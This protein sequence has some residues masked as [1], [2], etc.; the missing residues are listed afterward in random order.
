MD[1]SRESAKDVAAR[2]LK[3]EE[4][5]LIRMLSRIGNTNEGGGGETSTA[6][7]PPCDF[8]AKGADS[9]W[10]EEDGWVQDWEGN[11]YREEPDWPQD[12]APVIKATQPGPCCFTC[13]AV[14]G[15]EADMDNP[16]DYYCGSCWDN[17]DKQD[18]P[19]KQP[20][21]PHEDAQEPGTYCD[22]D[23]E[24]DEE[25]RWFEVMG[26]CES[27][28]EGGETS[29]NGVSAGRERGASQQELRGGLATGEI[30]RSEYEGA[31][32]EQSPV[33]SPYRKSILL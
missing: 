24:Q 3:E 2:E 28:C 30:T 7:P 9:Q 19:Q 6:L 1:K 25:G 8:D 32:T 10:G 16:G 14:D 27:E 31:M 22:E 26:K 5:E 17:Q 12:A 23:W 4:D 29:G 33:G 13:R 11:W 21:E 15:L 18:Q 20:L